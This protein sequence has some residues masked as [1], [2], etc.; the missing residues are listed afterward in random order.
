MSPEVKAE[1]HKQWA[2]LFDEIRGALGEDPASSRAQ[3]LA[4]RWVKILEA[5]MGG[6]IDPGL[7]R[8]SGA[9]YGDPDKWPTSLAQFRDTRVW[10]FV[11]KALAARHSLR[12]L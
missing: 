5:I 12:S 6:A 10:E 11:G 9:V 1:L 7:L 3:E 4:N 2:D 8:T